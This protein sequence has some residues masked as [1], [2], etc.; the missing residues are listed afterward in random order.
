MEECHIQGNM[1]QFLFL[2]QRPE[3]VEK[4]SALLRQI[5]L[6]Y[7]KN[8]HDKITKRSQRPNWM[9]DSKD[10][11]SVTCKE[12][13]VEGSVRKNES[14]ST[15]CRQRASERTSAVVWPRSAGNSV[16]N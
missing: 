5:R 7:I 9:T 12:E 3:W 10:E 13:R 14:M 2:L 6:I 8:I 15:G 16:C 11:V 4:K 1:Q